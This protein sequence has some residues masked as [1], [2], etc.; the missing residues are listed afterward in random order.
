MGKSRFFL[1]RQLL[2]T[3][4]SRRQNRFFDA[5]AQNAVTHRKDNPAPLAH[6]AV[7]ARFQMRL[8]WIQGTTQ[9]LK[10]FRANH[11]GFLTNP[12][13]I[14]DFGVRLTRARFWQAWRD[15]AFGR[16][17]MRSAFTI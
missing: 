11:E 5:H 9:Q 4:T 13:T 16:R 15:F 10:Q 17:C 2:D 14:G 8:A 3:G 12:A 7:V 6:R 1:T